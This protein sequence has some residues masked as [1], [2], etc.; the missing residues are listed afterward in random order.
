ALELERVSFA[1]AG[2]PTLHDVSLRLVP[3][4]TVAVVGPSGAGKSTLLQLAARAWDPSH[5]Q[6]RLSGRDLRDFLEAE[7]AAWITLIS[8]DI[9]L[10]SATVR[11]N[12]RVAMP[13]A[14]DTEMHEVLGQ[15]G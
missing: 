12:L 13:E 14:S 6:V 2:A 9:Y 10:F 4:R 1:Y 3:G 11:D 5:G 15:V 8:Q 7:L